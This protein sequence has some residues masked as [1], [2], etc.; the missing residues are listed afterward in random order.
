MIS[1]N[2]SSSL[3]FSIGIFVEDYNFN[4]I[5]DRPENLVYVFN[6][7]KIRTSKDHTYLFADPFL[8]V[9]GDKIYLFAEV[10]NIDNKGFINCWCSQDAHIWE[11]IGP[12]LKTN[13]HFSYPHI[14]RNKNNEIFLIPE[15][16][17]L[18]EVSIYK[19]NN[20][21]M[22]LSKKNELL[23]G[24][25]SDTNILVQD[26]TFFLITT[27]N[28]YHEQSLCLR[29]DQEVEIFFSDDLFSKNWTKHPKS[30]IKKGK[31]LFRNA[32]P[33]YRRKGRMYR[34]VQDFS[35]QTA[36]RGVPFSYGK[37]INV[38]EIVKIDKN[39]YKEKIV[40]EDY[41][42]K[43]DLPFQKHSRH[44]ISSVTFKGKT[45]VAI[46][47]RR[48]DIIFNKLINFAYRQFLK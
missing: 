6:S 44:H 12:V 39:N 48:S 9:E 1:L 32:G 45:V 11:N 5:H 46:D 23:Q 14:F 3:V 37:K 21:P 38:V 29:D 15:S 18:K 42:P 20:F 22:D 13:S 19:F 35:H 4:L 31:A 36:Y 34:F 7:R 40:A 28:N 30:P 8:H 10:Q 41:K 24:K 17:E 27:K 33:I 26:G 2:W 47:G 25:Y 16:E 43:S